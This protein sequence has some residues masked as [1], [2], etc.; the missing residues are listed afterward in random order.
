M[1]SWLYCFQNLKLSGRKLLESIIFV[2][3][4]SEVVNNRKNQI[5]VIACERMVL[6]GQRWSS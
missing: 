2:P 6:E 3:Y 5:T 4:D 1:I